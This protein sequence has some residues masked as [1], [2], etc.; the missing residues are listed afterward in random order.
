[1]S[2]RISDKVAIVG[3]GTTGFRK[4]QERT[5]GRLI[6]EAAVQAIRDAGLTAADIDGICG[7]LILPAR[8][9]QAGLGI[10]ECAWHANLTMPLQHQ[11]IESM[12]AIYSGSCTNVLVYHGVY[13][14]PGASRAA[15]QDPFRVQFG[16]GMNV[17]KSTPDTFEGA[18]GTAPWAGRYL[19]KYGVGREVFGYVAVNGRSNAVSNDAAACRSPMDMDDYLSAPI[20]RTPLGLLDIDYPVDG[21]DAFVLTSAERARDLPHRPVLIHAATLGQNDRP[22][23]AS[24]LDLDSTGQQVAAER[25]WKRSE[26]RLGDVDV[27]YPYDGFTVLAVRWTESLGYCADGEALD[28]FTT[29][30]DERGRRLLLNGRVP[31][32]SHGGSLSEGATQGS[33]HFREAVHQLRGDA[34]T[35]QI[36]DARVA[37]LGQGGFFFNAGAT[38]LQSS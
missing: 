32:N 6:L 8:Y 34:M 14:A 7:T 30:W 2:V 17:L 36:P 11:V 25:L 16:L 4:D 21:A 24:M 35:R 12:N 31:V 33:G 22:Y 23:A 28:C 3:V 5:V 10:A 19:Q 20:V 9:V 29:N 13:R 26:L 27:F 37:L 1:M 18:V 15:G 38:I